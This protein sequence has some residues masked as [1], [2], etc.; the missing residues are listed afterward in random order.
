[1]NIRKTASYLPA[2][3]AVLITIVL[4]ALLTLDRALY[5]EY[6]AQQ[7][8]AAAGRSRVLLSL[9]EPALFIAGLRSKRVNATLPLPRFFLL[10]ALSEAQIN[11]SPLALLTGG[12]QGAFSGNAYDGGL[13]GSF[14]TN[15]SGQDGLFSVNLERL[16]LGAHPQL[17]GLGL[18]GSLTLHAADIRLA[19][20]VPQGGTMTITLTGVN[21]P[22]PFPIPNLPAG[23]SRQ[24]PAVRDFS[25]DAAVALTDQGIILERFI[26][27]SSWGKFNATGRLKTEPN[28][29]RSITG[30]L[31]VELTKSFLESLN[32]QEAVLGLNFSGY[33]VSS[34]VKS[35]TAVFDVE[36]SGLLPK[37]QIRFQAAKPAP[38]AGQQALRKTA[39]EA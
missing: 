26:S 29:K 18:T 22:A 28:G 35:D 30:T 9:E 34:D 33:S 5:S 13:A 10:L 38:S 37:P 11:V 25:L 12:L 14:K 2:A 19:G 36:I 6:A 1:M 23:I 4:T 7:I 39:P 27:E 20:G 17:N 15:M 8:V 32:P 24:I 31:H 21:R 16:A 3:A